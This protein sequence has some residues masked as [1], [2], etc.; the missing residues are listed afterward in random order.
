[1]DKVPNNGSGDCRH[2]YVQYIYLLQRLETKTHLKPLVKGFCQFRLVAAQSILGQTTSTGFKSLE[3][4]PKWWLP[5]TLQRRSQIE[6][7]V[8]FSPVGRLGRFSSHSKL[9][10]SSHRKRNWEN[11]TSFLRQS[12]T[13]VIMALTELG[14]LHDLWIFERLLCHFLGTLYSAGSVTTNWIW[15]FF[16]TDFFFICD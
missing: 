10:R 15:N 3:Q 14:L 2:E 16:E 5:L 12:L 4:L 13:I 9:E 11:P 8:A 1:M 7:T 6:R